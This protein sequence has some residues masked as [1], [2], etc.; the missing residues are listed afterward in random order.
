MKILTKDEARSRFNK[1]FNK[2]AE[3][4]KP[5]LTEKVEANS[6]AI[7]KIMDYLAEKEANTDV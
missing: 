3:L 4:P 2:N 1:C 7:E 6:K 5:S